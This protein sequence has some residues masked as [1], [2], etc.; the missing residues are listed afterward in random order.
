MNLST[1]LSIVF[2]FVILPPSR[3]QKI[4]TYEETS[5]EDP[6][7]FIS[8]KKIH[9]YDDNT[10]V[11]RIVRLNTSAPDS[12]EMV[13]FNG[14]L[15]LRT[16]FPDG[17]VASFDISLETLEIQYLNFCLLQ[18]EAIID[19]PLKTYSVRNNFLLVTYTVAADQNNPFTYSE[20]AI[21]IDIRDGKVKGLENKLN[22]Y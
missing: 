1:I 9:E 12:N 13:C 5:N 21:V 3:S 4:F 10:M 20:W 22:L 15:S 19:E 14:F 8:L 7:S 6:N 17:S 2:L 18:R 11:V 16:I